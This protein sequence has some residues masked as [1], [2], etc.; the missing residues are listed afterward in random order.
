MRP[1]EGGSLTLLVK[2]GLT[3]VALL[4]AR[5]R[6]YDY[7]LAFIG[8]GQPSVGPEVLNNA[9]GLVPWK[10]RQLAAHVGEIEF[11]SFATMPAK[12]AVFHMKIRVARS[13]GEHF[14]ENFFTHRF[15]VGNWH[16]S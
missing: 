2:T 13:A 5:P 7:R 9:I 11:E 6:E 1:N 3:S 10:Q 12:I 14:D 15:Q 8:T 4:T 16:L